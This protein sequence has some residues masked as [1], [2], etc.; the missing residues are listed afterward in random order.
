MTRRPSSPSLV[1]LALLAVPG[2][3]QTAGRGL[4]LGA[5]GAIVTIVSPGRRTI[6][7]ITLPLFFTPSTLVPTLRVGFAAGPRARIEPTFGYF[8]SHQTGSTTA[9]ASLD[10]GVP[11]DFTT[12]AT[13]A[14]MFVRP[15]IGARYT[16]STFSGSSTVSAYGAGLGVR[17]PVGDRVAARL[18]GRW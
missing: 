8:R 16:T 15:V 1:M 14:Q 10:V 13:R 4:E 11:I 3:A 5:D 18:E 6:S 9:N 17:L 2:A 12:D 7:M